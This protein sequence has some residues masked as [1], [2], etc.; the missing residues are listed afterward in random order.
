MITCK[1]AL[2]KGNIS[3]D[4]VYVARTAWLITFRLDATTQGIIALETNDIV[5]LPAVEAD[6]GLLK[7]SNG[8][9]C[10]N[11]DGGVALA[12][13]LIGLMNQRFFHNGMF[14]L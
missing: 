4:F 10:I 8:F 5:G 1:K 3:T 14:I 6:G 9:V 7:L 12:R 2:R 13:N 11:T